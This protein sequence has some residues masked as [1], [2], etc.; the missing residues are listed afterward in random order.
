MSG[1]LYPLQ[2]YHAQIYSLAPFAAKMA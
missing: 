2:K 1:R